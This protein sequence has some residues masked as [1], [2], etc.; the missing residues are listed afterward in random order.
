MQYEIKKK[1]VAR[2]GR[3]TTCRPVILLHAKVRNDFLGKIQPLFVRIYFIVVFLLQFVSV[4][5]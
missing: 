5:M 4:G 2:V 1:N 3:V